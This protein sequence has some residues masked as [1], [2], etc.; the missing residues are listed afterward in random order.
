MP[1]PVGTIFAEIGIDFEPATRAQRQLLKDAKTTSL[2]IEQNFKN[3]G[4]RSS[5]EFDLMR[6]KAQNS[7]N[8]IAN[9]GK[10]SANDIAR[11]QVALNARMKAIYAEQYGAHVSMS[12][13]VKKNWLEITGV[14]ASMYGA[15]VVAKDMIDA[16]LAM[17]RINSAMSATAG[18]S[19]AAGRELQFVREES[20]RL[21][22]EFQSTALAYTKLAASA[23]G[24]SAEGESARKIFSQMSE[25]ITA[26]KLTTD[27]ANGVFY[28][29]GQML[30]KGKVQAEEL[31]GQLG[32]RL[33]G[34]FNLAAKAMGVTTAELDKMMEDGK[35]MAADLLPKLAQEIHNTYSSAAADAAK[36]GQAEINRFNNA[37]FETKA[38]LGNELKPVLLDIMKFIQDSI[39]VVKAFGYNFLITAN[40]IAA[41][42]QRGLAVGKLETSFGGIFNPKNWSEYKKTLE[43]IDYMQKRRNDEAYDKFYGKAS[44]SQKSTAEIAAEAARNS[45]RAAAEKAAASKDDSG[46]AAKKAAKEAERQLRAEEQERRH[47]VYAM[48]NAY[49]YQQHL[50]DQAAIAAQE[51]R[52]VEAQSLA[53]YKQQ[54]IEVAV[55]EGRM[56]V[57]EGI[58]Q[59]FEI[60]RNL[61]NVYQDRITEASKA[62]Q[63]EEDQLAISRMVYDL[64]QRRTDLIRQETIERERH[65]KEILR[66]EGTFS[67]GMSE[68]LADYIKTMQ[69]DFERGQQIVNDFAS[70]TQSTLGSLFSDAIKNDMKSFLE[71]FNDF[72]NKMIDA[73]SDMLATMV[74]DWVMAQIKMAQAASATDSSS[75]WVGTAISFIGAL[76]GGGSSL[77]AP[78]TGM[79]SNVAWTAKG[80]VFDSG[81]VVP[82][83]RGGVVT[84]PT[85]FPMANGGIGVMGE[86]DTEAVMPL[87]R[88]SSGDLGVR[89]T[90]SS[91][92]TVY[93][94]HITAVDARSFTELVRRNPSAIIEAVDRNLKDGG[95]LR[96][97][98]AKTKVA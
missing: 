35:L 92:S 56:S 85:I 1:T 77:S 94:I 49:E 14:I 84:S 25:G 54:M 90:G 86:E 22:L 13:K 45:A 9:S 43:D 47:I 36:R 89:A 19:Q 29:L 50:I 28:A 64:E 44:S 81:K 17:E 51:R 39:P 82:F 76:F 46:K 71:Y 16:S 87:T 38:M 26:L 58:R 74:T 96:G 7:F 15:K 97:T 42:T 80:N 65:R 70:A 57:S 3:L 79:G 67:G 91:G 10:A 40:A 83:A 66:Q 33:P 72:L 24:T 59:R 75:S 88:T 95:K 18:T 11:A 32:E 52:E 8:M 73:W 37:V 60:E 63:T 55:A 41:I 5:K 12:E 27:E 23:K 21:G 68:G 4:I 69:T 20:K 30:S 53:D 34:A 6:Q 61:L 62:A 2:N 78:S 31:R 48:N 98:I 93:N